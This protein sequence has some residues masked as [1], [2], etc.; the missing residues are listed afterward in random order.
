V[1]SGMAAASGLARLEDG[2]GIEAGD[3]VPVI[4]L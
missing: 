1:L 2:E 4:L 3:P